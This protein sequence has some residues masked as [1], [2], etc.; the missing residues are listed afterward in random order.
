[1][2]SQ[3]L[4]VSN[5]GSFAGVISST[6]GGLTVSGGSL[7]L[8]GANTYTGT[9]NITGG[10][11]ALAGSGSIADSNGV[12]VSSGATFDV[13]NATGGVSVATVSGAGSINLGANTLTL[14]NASGTFSGI[15]SG[16]GGLTIAHGTET[17]SGNNTYTGDTTVNAGATL[18]I[19]GGIYT[20]G[21]LGN[22]VA[23]GTV[24]IGPSTTVSLNQLSGTGLLNINGS[25]TQ[26]NVDGTTSGS[27]GGVSSNFGGTLTGNGTLVASN[28]RVT[29]T[30][31]VG[32]FTGNLQATN[33]GNISVAGTGTLASGVVMQVENN[34]I[35]SVGYSQLGSASAFFSGNSTHGALNI[36][37][38]N[39]TATL[40][41]AGGVAVVLNDTTGASVNV[42]DAGINTSTLTI[43][44]SI[45]SDNTNATPGGG[46]TLLLQNGNFIVTSNQNS[47]SFTGA[48]S[49]QIGNSVS[50]TTVAF[51][52]SQMLPNASINLVLDDGTFQ[53]GAG[54]INI[55]NQLNVDAVGGTLDINGQSGSKVSGLMTTTGALT[56]E[57]SAAT[58]GT[59]I[60]ADNNTGSGNIVV[61][62]GLTVNFTNA[63]A[64]GSGDIVL[65]TAADT[66]QFGAGNLNLAN[67]VV[68]NANTIID[69]NGQGGATL[70]GG[71]NGS[72]NLT[73]ENS[74]VTGTVA[75]G[76]G[77]AIALNGNNF[78][79]FGN[80]TI[81]SSG[82]TASFTQNGAFGATGV[83]T[84]NAANDTLQFNQNNLNEVNPLNL[85]STGGTL[86]IQGNNATWSGVISGNDL[87]VINT[88]AA[89]ALTLSAANTYSGGTT[90]GSGVALIAA[91][92]SA[93]GTGTVVINSGGTLETPLAASGGAS[94][95]TLTLN[96]GNYTQHSGA[97]L[98]LALGG[99]PTSGNYDSINVNGSA[100]LAGSLSILVQPAAAPTLG[101]QASYDVIKTASG[102]IGNFSTIS[103]AAGSPTG[104]AITGSIVGDNYELNLLNGFSFTT[105]LT[106][107][108]PTQVAVANYLDAVGNSGTAPAGTLSLLQTLTG[109]TT[110]QLSTALNELAPTAY[111][112]IPATLLNNSI[113]A[114]QA[115]NGQIAGQF[116]GGGINT[117]G[118]TLLKTDDTNPFAMSLDA[119]MQSNSTVNNATSSIVSLDDAA[120]TGM[121]GGRV[122]VP[123]SRSSGHDA[124]GGFVAGEAVLGS[125]PTDASGQNYFTGGVLSGVDYRFAKS[126]IVGV[127]FNYS[128]T[129]A[130]IDN[131]GSVL[132]DNSYAPGVFAGYRKGGFYADASADYTYTRFSVHR[133]VTIGG[134]AS[135]ATGK[136]DANQQDVNA[137]AGYNF[138]LPTGLKAGPAV[139]LDY[140]HVDVSSYTETGSP[141]DLAVSGNAIDSLRSLLGGQAEYRLNIPHVPL[142]LTITANAFWQHEFLNNSHGITA[143]LAGAGGSFITNV[144][145]PGRD[146]ALLGAGLNGKLCRYANVFANYEAQIGPKDQHSQSIMVG[147]AIKF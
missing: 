29:L 109:L 92:A 39:Q 88:G 43:A 42:I 123:P 95:S 36:T 126:L 135:T 10:T 50:A 82:F 131:A 7:Q 97:T 111:A 31:N 3:T 13:S 79:F 129:N 138:P 58:G 62:S 94:G 48:G 101:H 87:S 113:F 117:A 73:L 23:N 25:S 72:A 76:A 108:T 100:S 142:P 6:G 44:G 136:P 11:L 86:D 28:C 147:V 66:L 77:G 91:N 98:S 20:G 47:T 120:T 32:S 103:L 59:I 14:T 63:N 84:L 1:M 118:L 70:Q 8:S 17:L 46:N 21:T 85:L 93:L 139:G 69:T 27:G 15:T 33:D 143:S 71:L 132:T 55:T 112:N 2:G 137:L 83:V 54:N 24:N 102:I 115:L 145:N 119:A 141:A 127:S 38:G 67:A 16:S 144:P 19:S 96:T 125:Q 78:G 110:S 60:L 104:L 49:L 41:G 89:N 105:A 99:T 90:I 122:P 80:T 114:S 130:H 37:G 5:G 107:P 51:T 30:G 4:A 121:P 106:N 53:F 146:S 128:Y 22:L 124:W 34:S 26:I 45:N 12:A 56:L 134:S 35:A 18:N 75:Q 9:T 133:N 64:F 40:D 81:A 74:A 57:N 116:A 52:G 68:L 140:T 65:N 61:N